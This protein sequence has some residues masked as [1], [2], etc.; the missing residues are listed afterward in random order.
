MG[1]FI[2]GSYL[3]TRLLINDLGWVRQLFGLSLKM[4]QES[5]FKNDYFFSGHHRLVPICESSLLALVSFR[6][7]GSKT[8]GGIYT[9]PPSSSS[10]K[11]VDIDCF[12]RLV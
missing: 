11:I 1:G 12:L 9:I 8:S 4:R 2:R 7:F 5:G 3:C 10:G 6:W